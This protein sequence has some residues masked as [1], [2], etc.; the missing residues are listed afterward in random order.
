MEKYNFTMNH[1]YGENHLYINKIIEILQASNLEEQFI[2]KFYSTV[3]MLHLD[4]SEVHLY[5]D[6]VKKA[7]HFFEHY[8]SSKAKIRIYKGSKKG[9]EE[10][11][12]IIEILHLEMPFLFDSTVQLL[13]KLNIHIEKVA[14]PNIYVNR[15]EKGHLISIENHSNQNNRHE[16]I[17]QIRTSHP[18]S[19][20]LTARLHSELDR[21]LNLVQHAVSDW[22]KIL[23]KLEDAKDRLL[24]NKLIN[25]E[26]EDFLTNMQSKYFVF[27][28]SAEFNLT[29]KELMHSSSLG[30]F[31]LEFEELKPQ[32][33]AHIFNQKFFETTEENILIGKLNK[34]STIH[35]E[36]N[37]DYLCLKLNEEKA[38]VFI[39][40][41]TS[42]LYYQSATLLPII[43]EKLMQALEMANLNSSSYAGKEIISIVEALP[44]D[45]LFQISAKELHSLL[46]E[47]YALLF[48]PKLRLFIKQQAETLS[49]LLFLP[50]D[51]INFENSK[52]LRSA[53]AFEYGQII[54]HS[55][56]Q[57]NDSKLCYYHF[58]IDSKN[59]I[60]N[61]TE[62]TQFEKNL[63]SLVKPWNES[64]KEI[65]LKEYGKARSKEIFTKLEFAFPLSY[66]DNTIYNNIIIEDIKNTLS[67]IEH[68]KTIF[69]ITPSLQG[70]NN[71][72]EL[73]IYNTEELHLSEIMPIIQNLGL[74]VISEQ[75]YIFG[76]N[77]SLDNIWLHQ[78]ILDVKDI[79]MLEEAKQNIEDSLS[80]ILS[81]QCQND[82][83][84]QLILQ[85]N[86]SH[87][88]VNLLR[89]IIEYL[90]QI[91]IGYSREYIG[92]VLCKHSNLM[93]L[94]IALFYCMFDPKLLKEDREAL[95]NN[96]LDT[97]EQ[98]LN[99]IHDNIEDQIIR[100]I[101]D[102]I[103]NILRT[104]YFVKDNNNQFKEYISLKIDSSKVINIPFPK[105]FREIFVYSAHF[106]AIHLRSGKVAR[107]GIRWSDRLEDYRTEI[108]GLMKT[109][110]VK[111]SVIVPTGAKGGFVIKQTDGLDRDELQHKAIKCYKEFLSGMLDI[112]DNIIAGKLHHPK[113]I[114]RYD[115]K[116]PYLVVAADKGTASF[117]DIA[118][119]I[120]AE[121]NFWLGDAFASGGS[122]GYDHKKMG[123]TARG[124]WIAV[125]RHFHEM[126]I[127]I[128]TTEFTTIGIGDMSGDVFGNGMLLSDNIKLIG[129]FNHMHIFIDPNP[130]SKKSFAERQRLF[131][132]P[133]STWLDYN[134][135]ILSKG[136]A[137]YERKAK[138][139][140]LT[141]EIKEKFG[142]KIDQITPDELIKILLKSEVDLLWN[143]GIGTYVKASFETN[144]QVGDKANDSLRCNADELRCKVVGEGGNLGFTQYGR[145]EYARNGG[146]INTDAIDNSAGVDCSDHE[147]NIKILLNQAIEKGLINEEERIKLLEEM[148]EEVADLVLKDNRTQTKALTLAEQQGYEILGA[149]EHF[150]DVL[151]EGKFLDRRLECL[152]TKAQ[153]TQ[154]HLNKITLTRAELS[155]LLAYS[156][157]AI[158]DRLI[159][160]KLPDEEYFYNDLLLYFPEQMRQKFAELLLDHPL[161]REIITTTITNSMVNRINTFYVHLTAETTGHN[162]S[163]IARA[164]TVTRD[165][166][167]LRELWKNINSLDGIIKVQDQSKLYIVIKKFVMRSTNWL[168]RNYKGKID[169]A[170]AI[171]EYQEK[172]QTLSSTINEIALGI[173]KDNYE[174]ELMRFTSLG[175][176]FDLAKKVAILNLQSS[177]YNIAEV[178]NKY[179]AP[180]EKV[181][182]TYF[183]LGNRFSLDWLRYCANNLVAE[184]NWQKLAIRGFKDE[185]YDLNRK[186]TSSVIEYCEKYDGSEEKWYKQ[187]EKH[188]KL[189]DK[190][191]LEV[192]AQEK[193]EYAMIDLS[194]KKLSSLI[195]K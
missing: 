122:N 101:I 94:S 16:L 38:I 132:L 8:Q 167:G 142:L 59:Y 155:V 194:L 130:D 189:Y 191:I 152:P 65:L 5:A 113:N 49:C 172:I 139:L 153:F 136:A 79:K 187:N 180:V 31:K 54:N 60:H 96:L 97:I 40:L 90:Y 69:K 29:R 111:N 99:T 43:R 141:P 76:Q 125:V 147:V 143:G 146:R 116:D 91:K 26:Q 186:I 115:E 56:N 175:V 161:K 37:I 82:A 151:E 12:T 114:I 32:I 154:M 39:G 149:Q 13:N 14:H 98:S 95:K 33:E 70:K 177:S 169:I 100:R 24:K 124:A 30:T 52:K 63:Q 47:L 182:R 27:F 168:L 87:R 148:T 129:A 188:I 44:R 55:F 81:Q 150:I 3:P 163:D 117:S 85:A 127:N 19:D 164:Y 166:F 156:K 192:K 178:S 21:I 108:L 42:I 34:L 162:F 160:T 62:L 84:N 67:V 45:E 61:A 88:Q 102:L 86:L 80:A 138:I 72:A 119:Q 68:K 77:E 157:N 133:R 159:E 36:S 73:K 170:K 35:R 158:Y 134:P 128:K 28:G 10:N 15:D 48:S 7:F 181:A 123:I 11:H 110:I 74:N 17:I 118:N 53:L 20:E 58:I 121:Y 9:I 93:K 140:Q 22:Q 174:S 23:T 89:A 179:N 1:L 112:T 193:I 105:P 131:R 75:I 107:G 106:E 185:L 71:V 2:R 171:A 25:Q 92:Q 109:Q 173:Y 145:I 46:M 41:F 6:L 135:E 176:P 57:I 190:F 66:R 144:E 4:D 50:I 83:Y 137:I 126:N 103:T 51:L 104:N 64:L 18:L 195:G 183:V 78:F 120:A 184:N 165:L